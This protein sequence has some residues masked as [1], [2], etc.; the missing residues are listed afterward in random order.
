MARRIKQS[1]VNKKFGRLLVLSEERVLNKNNHNV[2]YS[3]CICD[4]GT[5][6]KI[7]SSCLT[8]GGTISCGC[9]NKEIILL[10]LKKAN[11]V[12]YEDPK[13]TSA[14]SIYRSRYN[15]GDIS[16]EEFYILSQQNCHYC[17]AIPSNIANRFKCDNRYSYFR[18][19][20]GTFIY[21]GLDRIDSNFP[22]NKDNTVPCCRHCNIAKRILSYDDFKNHLKLIISNRKNVL[23]E[24]FINVTL[25]KIEHRFDYLFV[26]KARNYESDTPKTVNVG[27][28]F[29]KLTVT[30]I[31]N[32]SNIICKCECGT[33]RKVSNANLLNGFTKSC[34]SRICRNR[35]SPLISSARAAYRGQY[36]KGTLTFEEFFEL[37]Q[38]NCYYCNNAPSNKQS[39]NGRKEKAD[40]IYNGLDKLVP[41]NGYQLSNVVPCCIKC[42]IMKSDYSLKEF[43]EW[44][45]NLENKFL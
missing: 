13:E 26:V 22:H 28:I 15:D 23:N 17:N 18:K 7:A 20:N 6:K 27:S 45:N 14:K 33:I 10:N 44:L 35:F 30:K 38:M 34:N 29:G 39:W 16:F 4:C 41:V 40:F 21:N 3:D 12:K 2:W 8:S 24:N 25:P 36:D 31:Q 32:K 19:E 9:Y 37:S 11:P 1:L 42:N 5:Y 43:N